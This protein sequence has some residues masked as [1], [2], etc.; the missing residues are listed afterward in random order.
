MNDDT[1]TF[2]V[3]ILAVIAGIMI[4]IAI[5]STINYEAMGV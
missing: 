4:G 5:G 2:A 1:L 3:L